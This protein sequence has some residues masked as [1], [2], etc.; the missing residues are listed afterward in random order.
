MRVEKI[1]PSNYNQGLKRIRGMTCVVLVFHPQCGHCIE[2]RPKWE[3]TK[4]MANPRVKIVEVNG[5]A[6]HS[7]SAMSGGP[8]GQNTDGFPSLMRFDKGRMVEKYSDER[9][10]EKMTE[11]VNRAVEPLKRNKRM[12]TKARPR[13]KARGKTKKLRR[14]N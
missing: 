6:M 3:I 5:S 13:L 8:I 10:P 2:M 14:K 1:E 11:F 7:N 9:S 12:A 4:R